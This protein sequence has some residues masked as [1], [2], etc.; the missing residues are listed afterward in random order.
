LRRVDRDPMALR[1]PKGKAMVFVSTIIGV[2]GGILAMSSLFVSKSPQAR[3]QL[4]KLAKYQGWIGLTMFGWGVW[5]LIET[6]LGMGLLSQRPLL[7]IFW[8]AMAVADFS[9]GLILGF[10]L[11]ATY[12]LRGN[13]VAVEKGA[14]LRESL[15]KF[16]VPLGIL[17]IVTSLGYTAFWFI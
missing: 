13:A 4:E 9:V 12:A 2:L 10:G 15:V 8:L 17:A 11:I 1:K 14:R 3:Q 7:W 16:Q 5:E 6:V